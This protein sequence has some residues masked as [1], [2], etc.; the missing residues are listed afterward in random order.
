MTGTSYYQPIVRLPKSN[1]SSMRPNSIRRESLLQQIPSSN[2]SLDTLVSSTLR[3]S[4][5]GGSITEE[6]LANLLQAY[7]PTEVVIHEDG[8]SGYLRFANADI[9]DRVYSLY[10]G[11]GFENNGGKLQFHL[12]DAYDPEPKGPILEVSNLPLSIDNDGLYDLFRGFGPLSLCKLIVNGKSFQGAAFVQYFSQDDS[13]EAQ[14]ILNGR[15]MGDNSLVIVPF[16]PVPAQSQKKT[17]SPQASG[18]SKTE[19]GYVDYMNLYIKNLEP[20]INNDALFQLFKKFGRIVSARVMSNPATGQS[21][22]YGF[23]SYDKAEEAAAALQEMNGKIPPHGVKP[24]IVAYHEPKKPRQEK[25]GQNRAGMAA[26]ASNFSSSGGIRTP[27]VPVSR[28]MPEYINNHAPVSSFDPN[29]AFTTHAYDINAQPA[30]TNRPAQMNG[31]GIDNVDQIAINM[32]PKRPSPPHS[33]HRKLSTADSSLAQPFLRLSPPFSSSPMSGA[34]SNGPSL[35]SLASGA[36][37]QPRPYPHQPQQHQSMEPSNGRPTLRRRGSLE[38]VSSVMTESSASM[39]R[40][41][42]ADAVMRCGDYSQSVNDIVDM[43]LTLKRK[44]R[45]LCLF[46][47]DFLREKIELALIALD[48]FNDEEQGEEEEEEEEEQ[49]AIT[50]NVQ[51]EQSVPT[52]TPSR[53]TAPA[54]MSKAIPIVAPPPEP[55]TPISPSTPTTT[56]TTTNK[57]STNS[58]SNNSDQVNVDEILQSLEGKP[59]HEKKQQLGDR[60]FPLVKATGTKQA[61]KVTIKLLDSIDL[62]ELAHL[63]YDKKKLKERV[64][65]AFASLK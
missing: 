37:I 13:N 17:P 23:V 18:S 11:F 36:N 47:Q 3:F 35:A 53:P 50:Q 25:Q 60:L 65:I 61:P 54:R 7:D 42:L 52:T 32:K 46:N 48:T 19:S 16:S 51:P 41:R 29:V 8:D 55:K 28:P 5:L 10:N 26:S 24:L 40:Q 9:A 14:N 1:R 59:I 39:Q 12:D 30:R 2:S 21:K 4:G 63:M 45:S 62:Y 31:L 34:S 64:D 49:Q 56:N 22:G 57:T 20:H 6:A 27:S 58:S 38:S 44:E 15:L 43:L 33:V